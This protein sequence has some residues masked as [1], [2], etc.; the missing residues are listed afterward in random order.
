[1]AANTAAGIASPILASTQL[2][3]GV[4]LQAINSEFSLF[5]LVTALTEVTDPNLRG[6]SEGA[7]ITLPIDA[8][9]ETWSATDEATPVGSDVAR[10]L[11]SVTVSLAAY[12]LATSLTD[13]LRQRD[14][15]GAY[16]VPALAAWMAQGAMLTIT[17]SLA[18]LA[19]SLTLTVGTSGSAATWDLIM[20]AKNKIIAAGKNLVGTQLVA[21]L[22]P[23]QWA[24]ITTDLASADGA[25]ANRRM[26]DESQVVMPLGFQGEYD[27]IL[28]YTT[29]SMPNDGTDHSGMLFAR[30]AFWW[31]IA[32]AVAPSASEIRIFEA[33]GITIEEVR[34]AETKSVRLVGAMQF[35]VGGLRDDVLACEILSEV[36]A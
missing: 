13:T 1:M 29:D 14:A 25:R 26:F 5:M 2:A 34:D 32:P 27:G 16:N 35:G 19:D 12:D 31:H 3:T 17:E 23:D 20:Q 15:T 11:T 4:F 8:P 21:M 33:M 18:T 9:V 36:V 7:S 28:V 10:D 22:H 30:G 6:L 24:Q